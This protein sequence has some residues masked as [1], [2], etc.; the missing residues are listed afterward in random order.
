MKGVA[1]TWYVQVVPLPP[2]TPPSPACSPS[3]ARASQERLKRELGAFLQELSRAAA[4]APVPRRPALGRRLDRRSAGLPRRPDRGAAAACWCSPTARRTCC[5]ASTRSSRSSR[6]SRRAASAA[7]SPW[8]S[9]TRAGR[10]SAT[11]PWPSPSTASRRNSAALIHAR[12]EGNPLFMVD[13]L[14]D[15]RD[16]RRDRPGAGP[17]GRWR[18]SLPDLPRELPESVRSMIER[19][20]DQLGEEDRRLLVAASVQGSEF[21]AAVVA[22]ALA[23][24]AADVEERLE[25]LERVHAFVRLAGRA[26]VPRPDADAAVPAS[27]TCST[28]M[29]CTPRCRPT[30]RASLSAAVAR[31]AG[32]LSTGRRARPWPPSWRCSGG[33]AG[34]RAGRRL[35]PAG[36]P[37]RRPPLRQ[38]GG[39]GAGAAGAGA[40][41]DVA[42]YARARPQGTGPANHPGHAP[43]GHHGL[44]GARGR[45]DLQR[46]HTSCAGRWAKRRISSRRCGD[47]GSS[48]SLAR[49]S[50]QRGTWGSSSSAWPS[51]AQTRRCSCRL[52]TRWDR[53]M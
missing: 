12:T 6:S 41:R 20:I 30:R 27:C 45:E 21:E 13:L 47:C 51:A 3:E 31:G 15:L 37:E 8:T 32:G 48:I 38:S 22:R 26:R 29:P 53:R 17:L 44:D 39:R 23:L 18:Q 2:T 50:R 49:R 42:G 5:W 1:P 24:D 43:D 10:S 16:R 9:L 34:V 40:A 25:T 52:I 11:W 28:R 4:L 14:R 7:R 46:A 19:K 35:F 36:G 33:G